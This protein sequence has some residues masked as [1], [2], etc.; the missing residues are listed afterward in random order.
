MTDHSDYDCNAIVKQSRVVGRFTECD[1]G[2][3]ARQDRSLLIES[4]ADKSVRFA[5][6]IVVDPC[7]AITAN[8][9]IAT[10]LALAK[11]TSLAIWPTFANYW[12][13]AKWIACRPGKFHLT[14]GSFDGAVRRFSLRQQ[15]AKNIE[16]MN[17]SDQS[18]FSIASRT[19]KFY[20]AI[21]SQLV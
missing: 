5:K 9:T 6:G 15:L 16:A 13:T 11:T 10:G 18:W 12:P 3:Q 19:K 21:R 20:V 7:H 1:E 8:G 14:S 2:D 4:L 17:F